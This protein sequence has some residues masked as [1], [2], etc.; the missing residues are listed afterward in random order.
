MEKIKQNPLI[1]IIIPVYNCQKYVAEAINSILKQP[2]KDFEIIIVN[3]GSTDN[4]GAICK[5]FADSNK[6][7]KYIQKENGGVSSTRNLGVKNANGSYIAFLDA[8]DVWTKDFYDDELHNKIINEPSDIFR[9]GYITSDEHLKKGNIFDAD[10]FKHNNFD[11][12]WGPFCTYFYSNKAICSNIKYD[13]TKISNEDCTYCFMALCIAKKVC[14]I[15]KKIFIYRNNPQSSTHKRI[16]VNNIINN[17]VAVWRDSLDWLSHN[18][19]YSSPEAIATCKTFIIT[20]AF[21]YLREA[22]KRNCS[23]SE[24]MENLHQYVT[25][26]EL[27]NPDNVYIDE[28]TKD[29][30]HR[31]FTDAE[32]LIKDL[33][34]QYFKY[35]IYFWF[36][37]NKLLRALYHKNKYKNNLSEYT[38]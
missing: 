35:K 26:E 9:F 38:Y 22:A 27:K 34:K 28:T 33:N 21:E 3:D 14:A 32:K 15:N 11:S 2:C 29:T 1:S 5:K 31:Y 30:Q 23:Y 12:L 17:V 8:D 25:D 4:S 20:Y 19:L 6:N 37:D 18:P 7:I 16:S 36:K 13:E 24:I 10:N